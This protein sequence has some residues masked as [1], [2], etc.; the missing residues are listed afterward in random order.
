MFMVRGGSPRHRFNQD[1]RRGWTW[2]RYGI[3]AAMAAGSMP[4]LPRDVVPLPDLALP[5]AALGGPADLA[6]TFRCAAIGAVQVAP[7]A[8]GADDDPGPATGAGE[9]SMAV[10]GDDRHRGLDSHAG[11]RRHSSQQTERRKPFACVEGSSAWLPHL[12]AGLPSCTGS[13]VAAP[14]SDRP[15]D[16]HP[17]RPVAS[18]FAAVARNQSQEL[19]SRGRNQN[20]LR[21]PDSG[22]SRPP[23]TRRGARCV[24][25]DSRYASRRERPQETDPVA[26]AGPLFLHWSLETPSG[27]WHY[28][29]PR[30]RSRCGSARSRDHLTVLTRRR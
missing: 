23:F 10:H 22:G 18:T 11:Q 27:G 7:I 14:C 25:A 17:L 6:S 3:C 9:H 28:F 4:P 1:R 5:V 13:M 24:A 29:A 19:R 2:M 8:P 15:R 30:C 12:L 20:Q 21:P 16:R 26:R